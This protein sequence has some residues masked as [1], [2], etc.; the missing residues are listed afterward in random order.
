MN[1]WELQQIRNKN[2]N[3]SS[4]NDNHAT[5]KDEIG[6]IIHRLEIQKDNSFT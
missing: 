5:I 1:A 6:G 3:T 4:Y 2:K